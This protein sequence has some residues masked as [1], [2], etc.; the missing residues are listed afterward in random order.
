M[1]EKGRL[2]LAVLVTCL[3]IGFLLDQLGR[4]RLDLIARDK[5]SQVATDILQD[6]NRRINS[7]A[8]VLGRL[9]TAA[10]GFPNMNSE[11]FQNLGARMFENIDATGYGSEGN[12]SAIMSLVMAPD[13]VVRHVYPL[14]ANSALVG[15]DYRDVPNHLADA[16]ATLAKQTP[17]VSRPFISIQGH[18]AIAVRQRY[19][20][21]N[22]EEEGL[23][24]VAINLDMLLAQL[25]QNARRMADYRVAFT[26]GGFGSFGDTDVYQHN[27]LVI[28]LN[29]YD[30]AWSIAVL[31]ADG[32]PTLPLVTES[33]ALVALITAMLML[34]VHFN[35]KRTLSHR[36]KEERMAKA[37]DA[38]SAG[39][40]I[41]NNQ[42]QLVHWNDTF[43]DM[44]GY[45]SIL[46]KGMRYKDILR[47]GLIRGIFNVPEGMEDDWIAEIIT[48]SQ[49]EE[50]ASEVRLANGRWIRSLSRRTQHGDLVGVRFDVTELKEAQFSAERLSTAK[51]EFMSILSHE[52][53]TPLTTITGFGKLLELDPPLTGDAKKDA[54]VKDALARMLR[55]GQE[56]RRLIDYVQIG[57]EAAP[58]SVKVCNLPYLVDR[59]I[60]SYEPILRQKGI[61]LQVERPSD[62][63][64]LADPDRVKEII[65]NL[66]SNAVKFTEAGGRLHVSSSKGDR[67]ARV[68]IAD[69]GKGIP[70]DKIGTIFDEFS[71][72]SS[73]DQRREGG[74]GMGL[75]IAKRLVEMHGG[76]IEVESTEGKGTRFT[77]S[78]P[79]AP[80]SA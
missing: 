40:V 47:A 23:V 77:F 16:E 12:Q 30:V 51:S 80:A 24:S 22:G 39:F 76:Q 66:C 6:L 1:W 68:T 54:Y 18:R 41:F 53:R 43:T 56:L 33:R 25:G 13:L 79:L 28:V 11:M 74:I 72:L 8:I 14:D 65:A 55:A 49:C 42:G 50:N 69:S 31:P 34:L 64:V 21:R 3:F 32:W 36:R 45:G 70:D 15:F 10:E 44:F 61:S 46:H 71:Q 52:L 4:N 19:E 75:A 35:V 58:L 60:S 9:V 78:L 7:N 73:S 37:I 5:A 57:A 17:H 63:Q 59:T 38:L 27:P 20:N 48:A 67:F 29:T 2:L 26:L 62:L